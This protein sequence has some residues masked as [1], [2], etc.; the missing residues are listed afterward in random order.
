[1]GK[2]A[3][4]AL[5]YLGRLCRHARGGPRTLEGVSKEGPAVMRHFRLLYSCVF[6][7][8]AVSLTAL[9]LHHTPSTYPSMSAG[10][11]LACCGTRR[12]MY[13]GLKEIHLFVM[14]Q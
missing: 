13:L 12:H 2:G 1:M 4:A 7:F 8:R 14:Q 9:C 5:T 6:Y 3:S 11:Q 10:I